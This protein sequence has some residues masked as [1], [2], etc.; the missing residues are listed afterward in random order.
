M[1]RA[2]DWNS[3]AECLEW[4]AGLEASARDLMAVA[5]DATEPPGRRELGRALASSIASESTNALD[6]LL[7]H[8]RA[9]LEDDVPSSDP[10]GSPGH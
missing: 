4:L 3:R 10:A 1:R 2:L 9:G 6:A 5:L 8:G 7:M